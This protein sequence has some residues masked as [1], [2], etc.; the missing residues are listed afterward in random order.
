MALCS[1]CGNEVANPQACPVCRV[2]A[3]KHGHNDRFCHCPRCQDPL[4]Q[5]DWDGTATLTCPNCRGVFFPDNSI[6][7]VLNKL[8]ATVD[9]QDIESALQEFRGRF[10]RELPD[11]V[12]YKSCPVCETVMMRRNY[13]TV[14]GVI[15]DRCND[16]GTWVD[17][18]AFAEL[19]DFICRGGDLVADKANK[20]R[21]RA[22]AKRPSGGKDQPTIMSKLF[23]GG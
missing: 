21:A 12:R 9:P 8:R 13:A 2:A 14:S 4:E 17:E 7:N 5:Q 23:G 10:T 16:H 20:T 6:E 15:V 3:E 1:K 19:A 18:A 22:S 11:S